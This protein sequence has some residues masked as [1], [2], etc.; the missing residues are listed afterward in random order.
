[1]SGPAVRAAQPDTDAAQARARAPPEPAAGPPP[2]SWRS[3]CLPPLIRAP[4]DVYA[5]DLEDSGHPRPEQSTESQHQHFKRLDAETQRHYL[6]VSLQEI[7]TFVLWRN[8]VL[9]QSA[10]GIRVLYDR[11]RALPAHELEAL[12]D[13]VDDPAA[14]VASDPTYRALASLDAV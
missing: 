8:S 9:S 11:W 12:V 3:C 7:A 1:M 10:L 4:W 13:K 2:C 5:D 6:Y 14:I